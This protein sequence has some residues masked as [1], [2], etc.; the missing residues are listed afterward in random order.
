MQKY[1][2]LN[3][4]IGGRIKKV[5]LKRN[6]SQDELAEKINICNG[7]QISNIE[8][9]YSGISITKLIS[10]CKALDV[11][12]DYLLFGISSNDIETSLHHYLQQLT[13]EQSTNLMNII[14]LFINS[15]GIE[16]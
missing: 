6:I 14:K 13:N 7:A 10:I 5:R 1:N 9:G 8:R 4:E 3:A 15:C 11:R 16:D 2:S 12:A